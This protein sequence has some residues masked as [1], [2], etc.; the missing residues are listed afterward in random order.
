VGCIIGKQRNL[1]LWRSFFLHN[2]LMLLFGQRLA[3][4]Y[5]GAR[6]VSFYTGSYGR[7]LVN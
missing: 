6:T 2:L 7:V 4:D 1:V 3:K 5:D